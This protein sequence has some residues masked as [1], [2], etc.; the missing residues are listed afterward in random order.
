M[1]QSATS[2]AGRPQQPAAA[3]LAAAVAG[4]YTPLIRHLGLVEYQQAYAAM[5][6]FTATRHVDTADEI[7]ILQHPPVYTVGLAG[8]PEHL[9]TQPGIAVER[10]DR[11]GQVTFH[12]P[13][14]AV[15]YVLLDLARRKLKVRPLV[16]MIEQAV[17]DLLAEHGI[18]AS[19]KNDAPGVYVEGAKVAALGLRVRNG[20][21]YHGMALN[22]DMDLKPFAAIDPCGYPG[23][24]VTQTRD[25]GVAARTDELAVRLA[26]NLTR[27]LAIHERNH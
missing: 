11:G 26:G 27:L 7:W 20:C 14:Q 5:R 6:Q 18:E 13:G 8:R 2:E 12:G 17:I 3:R 16:G 4:R 10:I 21:C 15:L 24:A 1:R 22:V 19:R 25:L 23:L 9:P